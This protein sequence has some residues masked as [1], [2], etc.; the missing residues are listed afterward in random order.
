MNIYQ[1]INS[2]KKYHT[3]ISDKDC[4]SFGVYSGKTLTE[5]QIHLCGNSLDPNWF[6]G[7]DSFEGLPKETKNIELYPE[8]YEGNFKIKTEIGNHIKDILKKLPYENKT[9]LI[10]GFY[11]KVLNDHLFSLFNFKP[12]FFVEVDCDLHI[13]TI[14]CLEWMIKHKLI[15]KDTV[16][17]FDDWGGVEEYKGGES[18]AWKELTEKYNIKH[19]LLWDLHNDI[20]RHKCFVI[21]ENLT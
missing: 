13:S 9:S 14:Q 6:Y 8:H 5:L 11:D 21:K 7:F 15:I 16:I 12:A 3:D 4:Y 19:E 10:P 20:H 17:Y 18:L 2:I 1:V